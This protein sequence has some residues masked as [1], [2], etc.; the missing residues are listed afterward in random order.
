MLELGIVVAAPRIEIT[1]IIMSVMMDPVVVDVGV[2]RES[3]RRGQRCGGRGADHG[4]G[5]ES[6]PESHGNVSFLI[7]W[8]N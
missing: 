1:G 3:R 4:E 7:W 8:E 6:K 2:L 5:R